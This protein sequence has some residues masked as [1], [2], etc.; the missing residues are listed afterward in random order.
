MTIRSFRRHRRA[1]AWRENSVPEG[2]TPLRVTG[3]V[4][5]RLCGL[6][7]PA[8][9][10]EWHRRSALERPSARRSGADSSLK[11]EETDAKA[12]AGSAF[13]FRDLKALSVNSMPVPLMAPVEP[14]PLL[15][16]GKRANQRRGRPGRVVAL[17]KPHVLHAIAPRG[18]GGR[19]T[20]SKQPSG[21]AKIS[22]ESLILAQDERWRRA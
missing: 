6:R 15:L 22:T 12:S 19:A 10:T 1:Q 4:A 3:S 18:D 20:R 8:G 17:C 9:G 2:L 11:T 14:C 16:R 5:I 7:A 13:G 21:V